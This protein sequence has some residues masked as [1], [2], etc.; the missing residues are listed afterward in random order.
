M[1]IPKNMTEEEVLAVMEKVA[2]RLSYKFKF[3]YHDID[4]MK[5]Q[6]YL[7]AI[8]GLKYYDEE[9]PLENFLWT[10]VRNRLFNFKRNKYERPD[11]PCLHCPLNAYDKENDACMAFDCLTDC[12]IYNRWETRNRTKKNL[13]RPIEFSEVRDESEKNMFIE[14][15]VEDKVIIK[16]ILEIIDHNLKSM[17]LRKLWL[18]IREGVSISKD[19]RV[20]VYDE[21]N[22]I[23]EEYKID[24]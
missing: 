22:R 20:K 11:K 6:A 3:G 2:N 21:I 10:H 4:D 16:E 7:E 19:K 23:L 24:V 5:Q 9:R 18:K 1:K 12:S 13:M 8:K 14:D 17:E 15:D